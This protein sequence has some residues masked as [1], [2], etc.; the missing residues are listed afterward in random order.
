MKQSGEKI[1]PIL[2]ERL[3]LVRLEWQSPSSYTLFKK[4]V[5]MQRFFISFK[6]LPLFLFGRNI[7][8]LKIFRD[9]KKKTLL[10]D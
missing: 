9:F 1:T 2:I 7:K 6:T 4:R 5:K 3:D 10:M 8:F